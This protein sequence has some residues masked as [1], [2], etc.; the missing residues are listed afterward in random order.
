MSPNRRRTDSLAL[1][2]GLEDVAFRGRLEHAVPSC[3]AE[4]VAPRAVTLLDFSQLMAKGGL[5][6]SVDLGLR[7]V[8]YLRDL[9]TLETSAL[10]KA[11]T[12]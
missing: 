6:V 8:S 10:V 4:E 7:E 11:Y 2:P 9:R 1:A 5:P 12:S 3:R